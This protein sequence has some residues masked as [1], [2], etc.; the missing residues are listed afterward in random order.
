[1]VFA[2]RSQL[3]EGY[4]YGTAVSRVEYL[5]EK[6]VLWMALFASLGFALPRVLCPNS[7]RGIGHQ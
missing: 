1:M 2:I 5:L 3:R 4:V 7:C 6:T